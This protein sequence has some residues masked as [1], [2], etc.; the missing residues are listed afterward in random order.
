[1]ATTQNTSRTTHRWIPTRS[2]TPSTALVPQRKVGFP[3]PNAG[4][5]LGFQGTKT[6][7]RE[8][9][10]SPFSDARG[11]TSPQNLGGACP[12]PWPVSW[13]LEHQN[14]RRR[15]RARQSGAADR[16]ARAAQRHRH[17]KPQAGSHHRP[18]E[19]QN[20][21]DR[22]PA[23]SRSFMQAAFCRTSGFL[24]TGQNQCR[25]KRDPCAYGIIF[26]LIAIDREPTRSP[27]PIASMKNGAVLSR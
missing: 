13:G 15:R 3:I 26:G 9:M 7:R 5:L 14:P 16:V 12:G 2:A 19:D 22:T 24:I 6:A 17:R 1:M 23:S 8:G 20:R 11:C 4:L 21:Y 18:C 25:H 27:D 10:S